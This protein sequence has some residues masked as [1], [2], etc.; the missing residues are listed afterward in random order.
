[1][2]YKIKENE[3]THIC[4]KL[5]TILFLIFCSQKMNSQIYYSNYLDETSE[6]RSYGLGGMLVGDTKDL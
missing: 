6:W 5:I 4:K 2:E 1:M 3:R